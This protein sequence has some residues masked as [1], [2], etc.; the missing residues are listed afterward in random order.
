M[1]VNYKTPGRGRKGFEAGL[2]TYGA[3]GGYEAK[4]RTKGALQKG[5]GKK[6]NRGCPASIRS[7]PDLT[8]HHGRSAR[9]AGCEGGNNIR[10]IPR[11]KRVERDAEAT[12]T[13]SRC[14]GRPEAARPPR[15]NPRS[16][17]AWRRRR[18]PRTSSPPP[19]PLSRRRSGRRWASR[20]IPPRRAAPG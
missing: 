2:S 18:S 14:R 13:P 6:K 10:I 11:V 17:W 16:S 20:R 5:L 12:V 19:R 3:R 9:R 7:D 15:P 8:P 4:P 1:C